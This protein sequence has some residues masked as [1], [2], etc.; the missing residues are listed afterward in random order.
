MTAVYEESGAHRTAHERAA[1]M[2]PER[3]GPLVDVRVVDLTQAL[4]GP[5]C[6]MVLADKGAD[7]VKVEPPEGDS[8]RVVGPHTEVD[9]EHF[10]GGY[11]ASNNRNKRSVVLDL[12][13]P[14]EAEVFLRLVEAADVVVENYRAGVMDQLGLGY[15]ALRARKPDLVYGAIRGFG[16]PRTGEGPYT[17]WPAYDIVAQSMSGLVSYTG[18][19]D[20]VR[21]A[22]GPSVGD[23]FPAAMMASGIL[24]ALHHAR[25]TGEGQFVDVGMMDALMALCESM[26]W[27][28]T[29]TGEIQSP[30]GS[31]HPSLCPF[32]LYDTAD[33]QVAIAAPGPRHWDRLC[34]IIGRD[35]MIDH[36][37]Y[38][39]SRRRVLHREEV[40]EAI[41]AWTSRLTKAEVVATLGDQV[42]C[43]PVN[44]AADLYRDA[45]VSA[46]QML[47]AVDHPGSER[48]VLTPNTPI[49]FAETTTGVYR[50]AP[51]LGEHADEVIAELEAEEHE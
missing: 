34:R 23:L 17:Y 11:F 28:Y 15:E 16:D 46:R 14:E 5:F 26:T 38:K 8:V 31:E 21:V 35:D 47:V 37:R 29:Y 1:A 2:I 42:P 50:P 19:K 33:G 7:V 32:E 27:R 3:S 39:S 25:C 44:N 6:T 22:S 20:G 40:R 18:T 48:P 9:D 49:R 24:A 4:A 13:E 45:H 30:R 41:T 36:D 10:F 43:G 51:K 12:K